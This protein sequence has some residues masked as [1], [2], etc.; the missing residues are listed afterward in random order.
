MVSPT[1]PDSDAG[2][3]RST[4]NV[5][6]KSCGFV[7]EPN[8][9]FTPNQL[10]PNVGLQIGRDYSVPTIAAFNGERLTKSTRVLPTSLRMRKT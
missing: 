3:A 1:I 10:P 6:W 4:Y 2:A 5:I 8:V 7:I 9:A